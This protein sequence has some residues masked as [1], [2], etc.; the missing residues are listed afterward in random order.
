MTLENMAKTELDILSSERIE[1]KIYLLRGKKVMF[2]HHLAFLYGV[3]TKALNQAVRRNRSRFPDDFM[4]QLTKSEE[5]ILRSQIVTANSSRTKS[6]ALPSVFTEQGVAMLSSVLKSKKAIQVNIQI[7]RTF[8]KLREMIASNSELRRKLESLERK[9]DDQFSA[10][11]KAI[12]SL[13][14]EKEMPKEQIGFK[15]K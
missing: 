13:I 11:F 14:I 12:K 8:T 15:T 3:P 10:V 2:D 6:R 4:F 5:E 1:S 9:Y 7:V